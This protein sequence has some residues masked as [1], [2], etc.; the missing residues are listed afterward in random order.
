MKKLCR[1]AAAAL[2]LCLSVSCH[3]KQL[4]EKPDHLVPYHKL[5]DM[6]AYSYIIESDALL[7]PDRSDSAKQFNSATLYESLFDKYDVTKEQYATSVEFY[8]KDEDQANKLNQ[9]VMIKL[10][11]LRVEYLENEERSIP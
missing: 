5:V 2:F 1:L 9:D 8:L 10:E 4:Q 11:E 6:V 3:K 7:M